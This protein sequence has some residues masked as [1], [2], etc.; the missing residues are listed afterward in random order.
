MEKGAIRFEA[1]VSVHRK[2]SSQLGTR[3][4]I[5]NLNSFRSMVRAISYEIQRQTK[6]LQDGQQVTQ[7]TLGWD[8]ARGMTVSQRSKEEA[9]DYRYFPEPD[10]P[11]LQIDA[12]WIQRIEA[13]LPELPLAR[14]KRLID[15]HNIPRYLSNLLTSEKEIAD[16]FEAAVD[17]GLAPPLKL[18]H[19][20]TGD[21]FSLLNMENLDIRQSKVTP[22]ALAELVSLVESNRI[23]ITSGKTVLTEVHATGKSPAEITDR[24]SLDQVSDSEQIS[25]LIS[26]VLEKHPDQVVE[27]LDG[28]L[29]LFQWFFGQVM[30]A[31]GGRANPK[32]IKTQLE[33]ALSNLQK[34]EGDG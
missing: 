17:T 8:V 18:A 30:A 24:L 7:E 34:K 12:S 26:D 5:K 21:L 6:L 27:Y 11:P 25:R 23:T 33:I 16:Y 22:R 15:T 31:A 32:I 19:W 28:K 9:H 4:E 20:I 10:L 2:G 29:P 1:N 13:S 3:T 14:F